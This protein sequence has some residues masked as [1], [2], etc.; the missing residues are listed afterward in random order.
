MG[1]SE[2]KKAQQELQDHLSTTL[3]QIR[4]RFLH[5]DTAYNDQSLVNYY[6]NTLVEAMHDQIQQVVESK[7]R[8]AQE[9]DIRLTTEIAMDE[10]Q[11]KSKAELLRQQL[12]DWEAI[13]R[14]I[15]GMVTDIQNL[16]RSL[17]ASATT[18]A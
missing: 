15:I 10:Q 13:G 16:E 18:G 8:E 7:L 4:D 1:T 17:A 3:N 14:S 2:V 11:R 12:T 9:A 6:F 5:P